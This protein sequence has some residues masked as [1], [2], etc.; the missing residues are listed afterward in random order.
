MNATDQTL[1]RAAL[2][3][4]AA[5]VPASLTDGA[6]RP[7][8]RRFAVYRNN[9]AISLTDALTEG[10][11]ACAHH[12]GDGMF[13]AMAGAYLRAHPPVSPLMM[14]FGR[15]LPS[16]MKA[17]PQLSKMRWLGDLAQLELALRESYHAADAVPFSTDDLAAIPAQDL[18]NQRFG[19]VP[20]LWVIRSEWPILSIW[21]QA[22][23]TDTPPAQPGAQDVLIT[24]PD[25]DPT[26]HLITAG[27]VT[28]MATLSAG[29]PL[30][31]AAKAALA[32]AP[33]HDPTAILTLLMQTKSLC[34]FRTRSNR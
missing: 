20:A 18:P 9:V 8:G 33:D 27:D 7:A 11:P 5:P 12:L 4:P 19:L 13:R 31:L 17:A 6:G 23:R 2:L 26:P 29:D 14:Q 32:A 24:R 28:F 21:Q 3:D 16:F 34:E 10:F 1:F 15:D 25:Y 22:M 30:D